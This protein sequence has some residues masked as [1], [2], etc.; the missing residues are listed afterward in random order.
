MNFTTIDPRRGI[1]GVEV[2]ELLG[3][4]GFASVYRGRHIGLDID[5]AVKFV[6]GAALEQADLSRASSEARLMA[7]LDHPSLLRIYD[8]GR[9]GASIY[10]V[11]EL[12]DGG[13][14]EAVH[15]LPADRAVDVAR[16]L[17]TGLQALHEAR[18]L[19]RDIKLAN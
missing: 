9:V 18:V 8:A 15:R 13:S 12:M 2:G 17:L 16:Q 6:E 1:P 10:L 5:V 7:R 3:R 19:H 4:G 14:C 11:L